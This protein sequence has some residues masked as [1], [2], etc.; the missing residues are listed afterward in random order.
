MP[1]TIILEGGVVTD[2]PT[3]RPG[4]VFEDADG[5]PYIAGRADASESPVFTRLSDGRV[6]TQQDL[7]DGNYT[8][9]EL[10]EF[11]ATILTLR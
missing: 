6:W 3:L 11:M 10:R 5:G 8:V 7:T 9:E 1:M 4:T 2:L